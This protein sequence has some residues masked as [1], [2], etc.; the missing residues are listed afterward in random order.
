MDPKIFNQTIS[1]LHGFHKTIGGKGNTET[2]LIGLEVEVEGTNLPRDI[3][4]FWAIH[5]DGSLRGEDNAEYVLRNP[6]S[7]EAFGDA[8]NYLDMK[9]QRAETTVNAT[10]DR[11]S[12]HVHL[13]ARHWT[14]RQAMT[15]WTLYVIF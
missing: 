10:S 12:V 13:N 2:R 3:F 14:F 11:T 8:L 5:D 6:L 15:F 9:F 1:E 7:R 4:R